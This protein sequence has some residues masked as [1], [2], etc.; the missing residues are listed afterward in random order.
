MLF[1]LVVKKKKKIQFL[2]VQSVNILA[3]ERLIVTCFSKGYI[4]AFLK[5]ASV[6]LFKHSSKKIYAYKIYVSYA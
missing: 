6:T 5:H 1:A 3:H 4:H 2:I